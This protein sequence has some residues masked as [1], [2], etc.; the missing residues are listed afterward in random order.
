MM[1]S[2]FKLSKF[3]CLPQ[4]LYGN[5]WIGII[6][7]PLNQNKE[8]KQTSAKSAL[9]TAFEIKLGFARNM[10]MDAHFSKPG[11]KKDWLMIELQVICSE[12]N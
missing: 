4:Q 11:K 5:I 2:L 1:R 6:T 8:T 9:T 3:G 10:D 12:G 7:V